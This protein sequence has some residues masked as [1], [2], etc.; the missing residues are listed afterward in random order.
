MMIKIVMNSMRKTTKILKKGC[1]L[2]NLIMHHNH[3]DPKLNVFSIHPQV[4]MKIDCVT[5]SK[6]LSREESDEILP[7]I[8]TSIPF[9]L[10]LFYFSKQSP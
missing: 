8:Q 6:F 5:S 2:P 10:K 3:M 9:L 4:Y 7:F 1:V